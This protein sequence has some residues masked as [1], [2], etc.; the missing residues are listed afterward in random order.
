MYRV[1]FPIH[2]LALMLITNQYILKKV[3]VITMMTA[4]NIN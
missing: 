2:P 3:E 4:K 1:R